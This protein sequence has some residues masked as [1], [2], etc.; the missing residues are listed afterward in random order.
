M[1]PSV[2]FVN[3]ALKPLLGFTLPEVSSQQVLNVLTS[4]DPEVLVGTESRVTWAS[5]LPLPPSWGQSRP[6][7]RGA[8]LSELQ[9]QGI[10]I[11]EQLWIL[12]LYL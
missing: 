3:S 12:C 2:L 9:A 11:L 8:P 1:Q 7:P 4:A 5:S 6:R 10:E